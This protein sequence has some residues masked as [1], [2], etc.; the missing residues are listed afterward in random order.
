VTDKRESIISQGTTRIGFIGLGLMG[1]RLTRRLH[2]SGWNVQAW[3]RNPGPARSLAHD[4]IAI[5]SSVANLVADS[6]VVLSSLANDA[7]VHSVFFNDG[8]VFS[9]AKP[10]TII[11]EMSTI[12]PELSRLLHRE[13]SSRDLHLLDVAISGSTPA[14]EAGTVT[15]LAGG[16]QNTFEKCTSIYE[17]I[18]KQWFLIGPGSSGIQ[19]K[20][21]VN[22]L[23]GVDMQAI[24]EAVSLGEHLRIDRNVLLNVLSK[25]TVI[26]PAFGGKIQKIK[27]N[28]YSPEFPLR[29]MSKDMDLVMDAAKTSGAELPAARV[30]QSVLASNLS[31]N[32]DQDLS[33]IT[34]CIINQQIKA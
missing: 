28:D 30:V 29:L 10:G 6:D 2:S 24:A 9:S 4:G 26:P 8:G 11:L 1:S 23:L 27:N 13:A 3:N 18:A 31:S 33:A 34:P 7:A 16:D 20:L 12:S 5:S 17:C 32:G 22:L 21:V 25:T 15:L 14:V 19:M